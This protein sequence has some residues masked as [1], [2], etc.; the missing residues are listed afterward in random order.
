MGLKLTPN[1]ESPW[2]D[3]PTMG[4]VQEFAQLKGLNVESLRIVS[5][6]AL[7]L[8]SN[9]ALTN[10]SAV[11]NTFPSHSK[12]ILLALRAACLEV[13]YYADGKQKR[14]LILKDADIVLPALL[15]VGS[16]IASIG[17]NVLSNWIYDRWLKPRG[18]PASIKVEYAIAERN[19][20][21]LRWR[22]V[23]GP[24]AE[25]RR[26]LV[27]ESQAL[28]APL[29]AQIDQPIKVVSSETAQE[30]RWTRHRR[31]SASAA[32]T[33]GK[34]LIAEAEEALRQSDTELAESL[35]RRS[36]V[37]LREAHLWQPEATIHRKYLH[38]VGQHVHDIFP[39]GCRFAFDGGQYRVSCPVQLSHSRGGFS[40]GA[41]GTTI[42]SIC[43]QDTLDCPHIKGESYDKV[44]ANRHN[45]LCNICGRGHGA[46]EHKKGRFYDGV[47]AFGIVVD[48]HLDHVAF[49]ENPAN[50]LAT[51]Q[52]YSLSKSE[53]LERLPEGERLL[54]V[55]GES[56]LYCHHCVICTGDSRDEGAL[57]T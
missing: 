28:Q 7:I 29:P 34:A 21:L 17:L 42:C 8:P 6:Q 49:V 2:Q 4:S 22:R 20:E 41:T 14:E 52:A 54:F 57:N 3:L 36:L 46:C 47:V 48:A 19:G 1:E 35:Y 39:F 18:E 26:L 27:E 51:I 25:V 5:S 9:G 32:R 12:E 24:V 11:T 16:A 45:E 10:A 23:E 13:D 50:P 44:V 53:V 40:I 38:Q 56:Q 31:E 37:K 55:Y 30:S 33:T 43:R 15:F